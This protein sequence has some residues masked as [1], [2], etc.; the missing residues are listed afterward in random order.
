[1]RVRGRRAVE[2]GAGMGLA[3]MAFALLGAEVVLTDFGDAVL[4][5]LRRNAD[6]NLSAAALKLRAG[7]TGAAAAGAGAVAVAELDW[8]RPEQYAAVRPPFDFVLGADCVYSEAAVPHFLAA[9]LAMSGPRTVVVVANE[10]RS[11]TVHDLFM[12]HFGRHF[13]IRK[14]PAARMDPRFHHPL[15]QIFL[16]KRKKAAAEG[17]GAAQAQEQGGEAAAEDRDEAG[18]EGDEER[19]AEG[20]AAAATGREGGAEALQQ[21]SLREEDGGGGEAA[22]QQQEAFETRRQGVALARLLQDVAV[23]G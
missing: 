3:G 23:P 17:D 12:A 4:G 18:G 10:F 22:Q 9:V 13:A 11:S 8:S 7:G 15:I 21:L 19:V 14:V 2:L 6:A 20:A 1:M 5:L 16:M